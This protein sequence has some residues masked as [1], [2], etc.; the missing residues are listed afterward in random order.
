M[1]AQDRVALQLIALSALKTTITNIDDGVREDSGIGKGSTL[2]VF[3]P[4]DEDMKLGTVGMS[5][6]S[7]TATVTNRA[8]FTEWMVANYPEQV[9]DK[10]RI[11]G[12]QAEV[13]RVLRQHAPHL[14]ET[15]TRVFEWA[16]SAVTKLSVKAGE[17]CGPG[18]EL[19]VP[20]ITVSS[21]KPQLSVRP[22]KDAPDVIRELWQSGAL[23]MD[24]TMR[25]ITAGN[26]NAA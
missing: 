14:I 24:G 20:G 6:P 8:A 17:P 10:P 22:T 11:V 1:N 26:T 2:S 12:T 7:K 16:E 5:N 9:E 3:N 23:N 4:L 21:K 13:L 18:R 15:E 25:A 19:D